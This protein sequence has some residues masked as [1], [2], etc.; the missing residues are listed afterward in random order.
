MNF[1]IIAQC[2]CKCI[3]CKELWHILGTLAIYMYF[4]QSSPG[5]CLLLTI[6]YVM[7]YVSFSCSDFEKLAKIDVQ[8]CQ[9]SRL[10]LLVSRPWSGPLRHVYGYTNHSTTM[11]HTFLESPSNLDVHPRIC[12][13]IF[14]K[15]SLEL[16]SKSTLYGYVMLTKGSIALRSYSNDLYIF[17]K[18]NRPRCASRKAFCSFR[19]KLSKLTSPN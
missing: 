6:W 2:A 13:S 11:V 9:I 17:W 18:P 4:C 8:N 10:S 7:R 3:I 19:P 15:I 5:W 14:K 16:A 1:S 12:F